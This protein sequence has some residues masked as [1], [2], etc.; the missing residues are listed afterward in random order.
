[1]KKLNIEKFKK[2]MKFFLFNF[3]IITLTILLSVKPVYAY[4]DPGTGSTLVYIITG[5]V[6]AIF[7]TAKGLFYKLIDFFSLKKIKQEECCIAIHSESPRYDITFLPIMRYLSMLN[8]DYTYFTMYERNDIFEKL[9]N[10]AKHKVLKPGIVGYSFLNILKAKLLV[11]TTPQL[12]I[13]T[14]KRSKNVE[15]YCIVQHALGE[16]MFVKPFAYDN[17]DSVL[18]CG[19]IL[20]QNLRKIEEIRNIKP[21]KLF[22]TGIPHYDEL[23]KRKKDLRRLNG[24]KTILIAPSWGE[25][26]LFRKHGTDFI[27]QL[28]DSYHIIIRPH[29][30]MK[31]SQIELYE[32]IISIKGVQIDTEDM[33]DLAMSK[34]DLLISDFSGIIHEFAFI[35]ERPVIVVDYDKNLEGFDGFLLQSES[36]VKE[37]SKDFIHTIKPE[38]FND[39]ENT[40]NEALKNFSV[41]IVRRVRQEFI[42]NFGN[43]GGIAAQQ[44]MD[45]LRCR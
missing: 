36:Q 3:N 12:D 27:N 14:F 6:V 2:N 18:C 10:G 20:I 42:F 11:T 45:I 7:F 9:P 1:M 43:A 23:I 13:M 24:Q 5:I 28:I 16:S 31:I 4:I 33:C 34:A 40:I 15:H 8:A 19:E 41:D 38:N 17:F 35:Y 21:K 25:L 39:I 29:P 37:K 30:Q 44:I 22:K 32:K 26:S